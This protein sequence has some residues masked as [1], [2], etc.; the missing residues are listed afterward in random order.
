VYLAALPG[1]WVVDRLLGQRRSVLAG[2]AIIALGHFTMAVP[3]EAPF[4]AALALIVIGTGLLKPG[5]TAMVG[6]LY[7]GGGARR[8]A[9]F[10]IFYMGINLGAAAAPVVTGWLGQRVDWHLGF[11]AAGTGMVLGLVQYVRGARHLGDVGLRPARPASPAATRRALVG[12]AGVAAA[13]VL[14]TAAR[15]VRL[16]VADL[17]AA[18][19]AII[20][21]V[22]LAWFA[23]VLLRPGLPRA[24]KRQVGAIGVFFVFSA[25][26]WSALEQAGSSLNLF[27]QRHTDLDVLGWPVPASWFQAVLPA[28]IIVL[29]PVFAWLWVTLS[30]RGRE[31]GTPAKFVAALWLIAAGFGVMVLAALR[32][33]GG[34]L[35]SPAWLL[36]AYLLLTLGELS[37]SPV[38]YSV[39]TA[40]SPARMT[41]QLIG[42]WLTSIAL[43]NLIAGQLA[44]LGA[45]LPPARLFGL[46]ALGAV[47]AGVA[48][49]AVRRP[50]AGL[51][52]AVR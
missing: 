43:G 29:A 41:S 40:L 27:A 14:L 26:C 15:P 23:A 7:P 5:V 32:V 44:G 8:D 42:V 52:G 2:G 31:P 25:V 46:V 38:G 10:S 30:A 36:V 18:G 20:A 49:L 37:F 34:G 4:F 17:A 9:G 3:G 13:L 45:A 6:G 39:V 33:E 35:A 11:A 28:L 1:G 21:G 50:L 24:E 47:G 12:L 22:A 16:P 19:S 51:M 48:L